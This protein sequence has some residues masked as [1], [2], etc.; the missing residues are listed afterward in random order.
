MQ[1]PGGEGV[2]RAQRGSAPRAVPRPPP[3]AASRLH[4]P[5]F[6]AARS[7]GD[8]AEASRGESQ[9]RRAGR[10]TLRSAATGVVGTAAEPEEEA[11]AEAEAV[12]AWSELRPSGVVLRRSHSLRLVF[13]YAGVV[14]QA[15]RRHPASS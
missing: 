12:A 14:A 9:K 2:E 13:L 5:L 1:K 3:A 8:A 6:A 4:V 10:C 11:E 7:A 15:P